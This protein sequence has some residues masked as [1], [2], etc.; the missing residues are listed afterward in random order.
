MLNDFGNNVAVR[1]GK[2]YLNWLLQVYQSYPDSSKFFTP[3]FEKIAG[4]RTLRE[5][6]K[7]GWT[8]EQIR[9]SW[10]PEL[11]KY[12]LMRKKYLLYRDFE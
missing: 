3:Y 8:E 2:L 6:I 7:L 11:E 10:G 4:T 1:G 5:Q 12:R 9:N